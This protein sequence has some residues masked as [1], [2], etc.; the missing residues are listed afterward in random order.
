VPASGEASATA[1]DGWTV[2]PASRTFGPIA[3]GGGEQVLA[4]DVA[5]PSTAAPGRYAV[6]LRITAGGETLR[7]TG[8]VTVIGSNTIEFSP[9]TDAETPWLLE[10]SGSQLNGDA[11]DGRARY[12]DGG[13][14]WIYKFTLPPTVNGGT[15]ALDIGAEFDVRSSATGSTWSPLVNEPGHV[16]ALENRGWRTFA[17]NDLRA[18]GRTVYLRFG[19]S[20][21]EE[22][23]GAWLARVRLEPTTAP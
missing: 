5:V 11:Y 3:A 22:G 18:G 17:L 7:A 16:H 6:P 21:P 12:A 19:D 8:T 1:P 4:F 9:G 10:S 15:V 13:T 23:W 14:Y 20:H 2:A